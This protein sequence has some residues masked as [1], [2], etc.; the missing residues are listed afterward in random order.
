MV[1]RF[2]DLIGNKAH[3]IS[4][5]GAVSPEWELF[6]HEWFGISEDFFSMVSKLFLTQ[7]CLFTLSGL[8]NKDFFPRFKKEF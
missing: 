7:Q 3:L 4:K 5:D 2:Y 8:G 6:V 1:K